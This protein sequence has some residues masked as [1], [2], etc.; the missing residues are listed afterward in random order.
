MRIVG[1]FSFSTASA[2]C[3]F[4]PPLIGTQAPLLFN[5]LIRYCKMLFKSLPTLENAQQ[6]GT[7]CISEY[8]PTKWTVAAQ[9]PLRDVIV[10]KDDEMFP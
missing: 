2:N 8:D 6:F 4:H 9:N 7:E 3:S 5:G 10:E 1:S